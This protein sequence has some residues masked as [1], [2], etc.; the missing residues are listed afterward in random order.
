MACL[1]LALPR[2]WPSE[3]LVPVRKSMGSLGRRRSSRAKRAE[4]QELKWLL[5]RVVWLTTLWWSARTA[6]A[7]P[8]GRLQH[9]AAA[10][11]AARSS[12]LRLSGG[13]LTR[14][15][16]TGDV[17]A[18]LA[19]TIKDT[20]ALQRYL[21][22]IRAFL[23]FCQEEGWPV[24]PEDIL[25]RSLS[26]YMSKQAFDY[27]RGPHVGD[28]LMNGMHFVWPELVGKLPRAWRCL[29]GWHKIWIHGEGGPEAVELLA[30]ME[31]QMRADNRDTEADI[32]ALCLDC[33]LR[34]GEAFLLRKEDYIATADSNDLDAMIK[35][36]VAE[37]NETTKTGMRQGV[38]LDSPYVIKLMNNRG[39]TL[40]N[41]DKF[42]GNSSPAKFRT[43]WAAAAK[44]LQVTIG[45]VHSIRH[46]GPSHDAATG[47]RTM[48]QIQ[49]RGRWSSERS[50][51]R[52]AKSHTWLQVRARL[53]EDILARGAAILACREQRPGT[54]KE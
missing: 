38:R 54:A 9:H 26:Y 23:C 50:V 47:Y 25:D 6:A 29:H 20:T 22:Q 39:A 19:V 49:R 35:L 1:G 33:Y 34:I 21:P 17:E 27:E 37:R 28:C 45:P 4:R 7:A 46:S 43:A 51:L 11:K 10:Q 41:G 36:G 15:S 42:F 44:Q 2:Q 30:C 52:Y 14:C 18:L 3:T 40:K 24:S 31:A 12:R 53:P 16:S 5:V 13:Q 48:W 8:D 32:L